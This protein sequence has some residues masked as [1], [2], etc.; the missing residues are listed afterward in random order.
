MVDP[1]DDPIED[2]LA[3]SRDRSE[4]FKVWLEH[5][6]SGDP[7]FSEASALYPDDMDEWQAAVYLL[8]GCGEVCAA[9]GADVLADRSM[10][11]VVH[12]LE[13]PGRAWSSSEGAV[14]QWAAHFWDVDRH[15]ATFPYVF[16]QFY[17][18][19]WVTACHVRKHMPPALTVTSGKEG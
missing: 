2:V 14:M 15:P 5:L 11:P 6:R 10:A 19:R 8:S 3:R 17:F 1:D 4:R 18:Q 12:E 13:K 16:E 7:A 9:L